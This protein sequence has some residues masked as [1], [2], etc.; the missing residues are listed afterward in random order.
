MFRTLLS[1]GADVLWKNNKKKKQYME[2]L[3]PHGADINKTDKKSNSDLYD[4][5]DR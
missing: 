1:H 4:L 3:L 5:I 2:I